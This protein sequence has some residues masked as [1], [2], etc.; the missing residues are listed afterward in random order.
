MLS[1]VGMKV[2]K[3]GLA[4]MAVEY[5]SAVIPVDMWTGSWPLATDM[6]SWPR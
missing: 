4:G 3:A 2:T 6:P 5:T 1:I